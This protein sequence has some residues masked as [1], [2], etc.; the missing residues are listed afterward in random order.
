[1]VRTLRKA[2]VDTRLY[3]AELHLAWKILEHCRHGR[4][5]EAKATLREGERLRRYLERMKRGRG[6]SEEETGRG[7]SVKIDA[8]DWLQQKL[9]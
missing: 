3:D 7:G 1:M 2:L 6:E 8:S 4:C 9:F 5:E